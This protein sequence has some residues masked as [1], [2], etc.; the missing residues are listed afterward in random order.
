[1]PSE[2]SQPLFEFSL[3][4]LYKM[5]LQLGNYLR[6]QFWMP[7]SSAYSRSF[8]CVLNVKILSHN[9]YIC[10]ACKPHPFSGLVAGATL[11][12]IISVLYTGDATTVMYII[13]AFLL[14]KL[15][16]DTVVQPFVL[17]K[18][19]DMHPLLVLLAVIIGGKLF[20]VFGMLLS[21]PVTGLIKVALAGKR[22]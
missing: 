21:V 16:D 14:M 2:S 4:L 10:W 20:G 13:S 1:M 22:H 17:A 6:G 5:D 8:L 18:S 12:V 11:A 3:N 9:R 7:A 19:V 15:F